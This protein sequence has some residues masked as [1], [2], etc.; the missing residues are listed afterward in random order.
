MT[1]DMTLKGVG[2]LIPFLTR[3][4]DL[5]VSYTLQRC[6]PETIMVTI[7]LLGTRV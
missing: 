3:L 5:R 4:D 7:M 6:R 1:P 2:D